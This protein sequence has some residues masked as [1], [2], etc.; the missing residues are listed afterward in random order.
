MTRP[1]VMHIVDDT[2]AGG[3]MRVLEFIKQSPT[4]NAAADHQVKPVV[5]GALK[6]ERHD[7]D[8]VVSH[9]AISWRTLPALLALRAANWGTPLVHVEHSY[10][11]GFV[12][13]CV[14]NTKRFHTLLKAGFR[15]FD[16]VVAVSDGQAQWL[17]DAGLVANEKLKTIQSCVDLKMF[18]Y[19]APQASSPKV[20]G[21][22]GRF[23]QQKGFDILVEAFRKLPNRDVELRLYGKGEQEAE[24][25]A[26]AGNDKRIKFCGFSDEP[27]ALASE[28]DVFLMPSRWEA[29]GLVGIEALCAGRV[30]IANKIDGLQDHAAGGAIFAIGPSVEQWRDTLADFLRCKSN[31]PTNVSYRENNKLERR[32]EVCWM[33]LIDE[34]LGNKQAE[35]QWDGVDDARLAQGV[36][37]L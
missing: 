14:G 36:S 2:T 33:N 16:R 15:I 23:D 29:Y 20:F 4:L 26:L 19:V 25:R 37:V 21:A 5:R 35:A 22:V 32:F 7:A 12:E 34:I 13:H 17:V 11:E 6:L 1:K 28:L 31:T 18:R 27:A 24:L 30:L 9:L 10:T 8:L 3:V